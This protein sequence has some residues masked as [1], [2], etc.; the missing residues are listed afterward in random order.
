MNEK[1]DPDIKKEEREQ[2]VELGADITD[3][4]GVLIGSFYFAGRCCR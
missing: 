3:F 2:V 1:M 4:S